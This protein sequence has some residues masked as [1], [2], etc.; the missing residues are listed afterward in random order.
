MARCHIGR[1]DLRHD[2]VVDLHC[3]AGKGGEDTA[4]SLV[5]SNQDGTGAKQ[6]VTRANPD[7]WL[8]VDSILG[9]SR[10]AYTR[11]GE[12]EQDGGGSDRGDRVYP[13]SVPE[14]RLGGDLAR[15]LN[16]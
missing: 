4:G 1:V 11:S 9:R 13:V 15:R 8:C 12:R 7:P 2:A 5:R 6:D 10:C 16:H 14:D 3:F